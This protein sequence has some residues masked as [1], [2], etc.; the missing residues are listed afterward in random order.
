MS[1]PTVAVVEILQAG[2][3][4]S[5]PAQLQFN[6]ATWSTSTGS[7]GLGVAPLVI[8]QQNASSPA[9]FATGDGYTFTTSSNSTGLAVQNGQAYCIQN[10]TQAG[11][12]FGIQ[13]GQ[14][15]VSM[16]NMITIPAGGA[17]SF[18]YNAGAGGIV[19]IIVNFSQLTCASVAPPPANPT[20]WEELRFWIQAHKVEAIVIGIAAAL[21]I[22]AIL[23]WLGSI[24]R[25]A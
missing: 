13:I 15:V 3:L 17:A 12:L 21:L 23:A 9:Y 25:S 24:L 5:S 20:K 1:I 6:G 10:T 14:Q 19:P 4:N 22:I 16:P 11:V 18:V 7:Q 8:T 2:S